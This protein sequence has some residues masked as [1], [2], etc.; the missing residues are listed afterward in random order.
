MAQQV[1]NIG[2][3][4]NDNTGDTIRTAFSKAKDNFAELYTLAS[5]TRF[6]WVSSLS[7]LPTPVSG[8]ITL[9]A[10]AYFFT[11]TVDLLGNRLNCT[12][13]VALLGSSSETAGIKST[14]LGAYAMI[15]STYSLPIRNLTLTAPSGASLF[16]LVAGSSTYALDWAAVNFLDTANIGLISGYGNTIFNDGA[17]LNS[18]GLT[19]GGTIGTVAFNNYLFDV[20]SGTGI[21]VPASVTISRRFRINYSSAVVAGGATGL[22]VSGSAT[23]ASDS[24]ILDT[25]NFSGAGTYTTG[26]AYSDNKARFT[27]CRGIANSSTLGYA[28]MIGNATATVIAAPATPVLIAGTL[29]LE[30]ISQRFTLASNALV[31]GSAVTANYEISVNISATTTANNV[32]AVYIYKNGVKVTNS[33]NSAT[34]TAAGKAESLSTHAALQLVSTDTVAVWV[35]NKTAGNNITVVNCQLI[36]KPVPLG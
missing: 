14:G 35:E 12:G 29:T 23:I 20:T 4:A 8:V 24:Y 21:T 19:F 13:L 17:F 1:I 16:N 31:C 10:G 26:V 7:D 32:V 27:N 2:T 34:A 25:M 18:T 28:T 11:D 30:S 6:K 15:T 36:V 3:V 5:R 33:E 22:N 9:T